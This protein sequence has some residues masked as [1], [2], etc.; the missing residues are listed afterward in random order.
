MLGMIRLSLSLAALAVSVCAASAQVPVA[1]T[2]IPLWP[3]GTPEPAQTQLPE[4]SRSSYSKLEPGV[5]LRSLSNVTVP[6]LTVYP[7]PA[8]VQATGA[9]AVV[10]PGGGYQHLSIVLEGS[11]PCQWFNSL[12]IFCVVAKYRVPWAVR[13]PETYAP[14]EDAQQAVRIVRGHAAAW[15][16]DPH[17]IGVM[18]FSAG[19]HLSVALSQHF[20]DNHV[21]STPAARDVDASVTARPD[22][23]ILGYPAYLPVPPEKRVLDPHLTPNALTPPTF[24]VQ[25]ENDWHYGDSSIVYYRAL[26]DAKVPA[27]MH[28][29]P[30]GGHGFGMHPA[31]V[32]PEHWADLAATWLHTIGIL[33]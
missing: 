19:G 26:M 4:S 18:G 22:F 9:A 11:E 5:E 15:G 21:L 13:Y 2:V 33:H 24:I 17:R 3:H 25:A 28:L 16:L 1:G 7:V 32:A 12:G 23:V 27:E 29:Y 10:F 6:T 30:N 31:G 14:L 20:D 8:G